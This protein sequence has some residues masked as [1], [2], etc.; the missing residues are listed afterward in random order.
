MRNETRQAF[1]AYLKQIETL[2]GVPDATTKFTAV[3]SVEQKLESHIQ[4][5]SAFLANVNSYSVEQQT[6]EKIGLSIGATI[7]GRTDTTAADRAT[8]DPTALDDRQY[9]C[10]QTNFDTHLNY[11][12][13]DA[14]AKFPDFQTRIRNAIVQQMGRDRLMI[15][16]NGTS[17]AATTNRTTNPLL[18][19]VNIGWLKKLQTQAAARYMTQGATASQIRV[20]PGGDYANLDELVY[21]MRSNLLAP[22][23]ARDSDFVAVCDSSMLD[24][25][26][27][28]MI[29]THGG[30]P[31]ESNALDSML[32][33]KK[34]GGL[35]VAE[36]PFFP[37]RTVFLTMLGAGG[38][39]NLS[40]YWQN[41]TR[42]RTVLDNA[43]RDRI[44]NYES[45]NESYDIEDLSAACAAVNIK[46]PN[47]AGGWA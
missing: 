10:K 41:G 12:K 5:S 6:G 43:K 28:P 17:A 35:R 4:E 24:E 23:F 42:R 30:T 9:A 11:S 18:Q 19:D 27:F 22:W 40:I 36:V 3:P 32:A 45:V 25:K 8:Q 21:D 39:S 38:N 47:G 31:T 29:A 44:E 1:N 15:G 16:W 14:W 13:L 34:L 37:A 33:A 2:N 7:A 20:G 26:Y 46:L